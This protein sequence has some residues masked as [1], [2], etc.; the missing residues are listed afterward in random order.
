MERIWHR[1]YEESVPTDI[2][3]DA[4]SS[5]A[6]VFDRACERFGDRDAFRCMGGSL[7]YAEFEA[8]ARDFA[9]FLQN[10]LGLRKG[11]RVALMMPN[12][13][14]YPVALYA[15]LRAG[16]IAVNV[17]PLYTAREL[18]AQLDDAEPKAIV[19]VENF[20]A[21][22]AAVTPNVRPAHVVVTGMGD[23]LGF[24]RSLL[25]NFVVRYV[26]K[27]VPKYALPGA[28]RW[29]DAVNRGSAQTLVP[30]E[31]S[32]S[33]LA[34]LQYTGGTT[35]RAKG[36]QLTHRNMVANVEQISSWLRRHEGGEIVV[37]P[38]PLYHIFSLTANL[39]TFVK[40]G[41]TILLIPNPRD[42]PGFVKTLRSQPFTAMTGVNTLFNALIHNEEFTKLDFTDF[43]LAV[44]GGM[45]VQQRVAERWQEITGTPIIE[46]YGLTET[47]PVVTA[48]PLYIQAFTGAIG[49]PMP[50]TDVIIRDTKSGEALGHGERGELCVK[51]PQVMQGYWGDQAATEAAFTPDGWLRTGD[52]AVMDDGGWFYIVDRMKDMILVSGFNVIPSEVETVALSYEGVMEA[53]CVGVPQADGNE[54]V[55]LFVVAEHDVELDTDALRSHCRKNLAGYKVPHT[56]EVRSDLPK[57][58]VG[59]ILRRAL[60]DEVVASD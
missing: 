12:V 30:P 34:F 19:L 55:R 50:S 37:T 25:V 44:G 38:L 45:S 11:D 58:N 16:L 27:L 18:E 4:F 48:N 2:D 52:V 40:H 32:S 7:T 20:C 39:L 56:I 36:A 17:N 3:P 9:A 42:I 24:P 41:G 1:N 51:G 49:L 29:R 28:W 23:M 54:S 6:E 59:K 5:L 26:R 8:R 60:R 43:G 53:A 57:T 14:Q 35:G 31:L 21:T 10:D 33:D 22:L 13:I 47:A 46:G 15:V